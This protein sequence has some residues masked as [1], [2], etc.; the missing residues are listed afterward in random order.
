ME[1]NKP[2]KEPTQ[3]EIEELKKAIKQI[4]ELQ[5]KQGNQKKRPR[6]GLISIEF[7]GV[8]HQNKIINFVFTFIMNF[9]FAYFVIEIFNFAN[10]NDIIYVVALMLTYSI[11]EEAF[12][13]YILVN[14]FRFVLRS[15]GT[16]FFFGYLF[17]F[18]ILDQYIFIHTFNFVNGTLLA[19][20]VLFF[21]I[22]RYLFGTWLRNYFRT[23]NMR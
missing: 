21:T 4:E 3:E 7:G 6:R 15:F 10:Y 16:V 20:F 17:I 14:H 18:F 12:K 22:A 19:F 5:K 1:E 8:F 13:R 23:H 9:T 11:F 2:K